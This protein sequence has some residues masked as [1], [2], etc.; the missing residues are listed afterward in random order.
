MKNLRNRYTKLKVTAKK[1]NIPVELTYEEYY[2]LVKDWTCHYDRAPLSGYGLDRKDSG[3][4]YSFENCVPCCAR[5]NYTKSD[6]LSYEEMVLLMRNRTE[7]STATVY[8][9]SFPGLD[10]APQGSTLVFDGWLQIQI[11]RPDQNAVPATMSS[12]CFYTDELESKTSVVRSIIENKLGYNSRRVFA[13]KCEVRN[14]TV[15]QSRHF[16]DTNHIKGYAPAPAIGL[17]LGGELVQALSYKRHSEGIEVYRLASK[18]GVSVIGGFSRLLNRLPEGPVFS[19]VDRRYHL[20]RGLLAVGFVSVG[21]T[22]G[23]SWTDGK[24]RYNRLRCTA[25]MDD[26]R[27]SEAEHARELGWHKVYDGGQEK[28]IL[29]QYHEDDYDKLLNG[30]PSIKIVNTRQ[31]YLALGRHKLLTLECDKGHRFMRTRARHLGKGTCPVCSKKTFLSDRY[32]EELESISLKLL[33]GLVYN[34][35]CEVTVECSLG[36]VSTRQIRDYMYRF[37]GCPVCLGSTAVTNKRLAGSP[38]SR[39]RSVYDSILLV[40]QSNGDELLTSPSEFM[41]SGVH[42]SSHAYVKVKCRRGHVRDVTWFTYKNHG[43][44]RC[45]HLDR[46]EEARRHFGTV[47]D[48]VQT[49]MR[50]TYDKVVEWI[51]S[52]GFKPITTFEEFEVA[53][54][55]S[56][57]RNSRVPVLYECHNGH[58]GSIVRGKI[59]AKTRSKCSKCSKG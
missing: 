46:S 43:C 19:Y 47:A 20:G 56:E 32:V 58:M 29:G 17:L 33:S 45:S 42:Q 21:G 48:M 50:E 11:L 13:R 53:C 15:D 7:N 37:R 16:F 3:G 6:K 44:A 12:M 41:G 23:F 54:R 36:H 9:D 38:D 28:F 22:R 49:G 8:K 14:L 59:A 4:P 24:R 52:K 5:C 40:A 27:L 18:M 34:K 2:E 30:N 10:P 26:R 55:A 25:N 51:E 39:R 31:E 57:K 35:Y 1:R